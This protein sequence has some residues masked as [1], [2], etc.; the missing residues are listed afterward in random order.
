MKKWMRIIKLPFYK[1]KY[2]IILLGSERIDPYW[3]PTGEESWC[4][5]HPG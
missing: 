3:G 5:V 1:R 4:E 2:I